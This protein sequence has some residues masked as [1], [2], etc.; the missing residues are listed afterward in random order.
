[1]RRFAVGD[2]SGRVT[3]IEKSAGSPGN[4]TRATLL[5]MRGIDQD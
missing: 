3:N 1:M 2:G 4:G 5:P